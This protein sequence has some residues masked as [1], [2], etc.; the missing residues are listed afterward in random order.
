MVFGKTNTTMEEW[1]GPTI[2]DIDPDDIKDG[3]YITSIGI[4]LEEV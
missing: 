3:F 4:E 2:H 1:W